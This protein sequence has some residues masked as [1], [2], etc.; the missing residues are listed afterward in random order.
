M[1]KTSD[2]RHTFL[3]YFERE[4]HTIV[5]SSSLVP[6][7]DPSLL[8]TNA[9]M[10]QFKDV[11]LGLEEREYSRATTS[12]RCVRAGG[13][14]NDLDN[15]GYT[16]RHHTFFEMLGN[17]SFGEYFKQEAI[18]FAWDLLTR[19]FG[20]PP[21]KLWITVFEQDDEAA[22]I[23]LDQ[24]GVHPERFSRC[25]EKDNFWVMGDTGPCGPCSEIFFDHGPNVSGGPPGS[26]HA[27]GDRYVEIWN[28]VFMQYERSS[29]S[30]LKPI[31]K[32]S[33]DTGMGL[34]RVAAIL[35]GVQDNYDIDLFQNLLN[36]VRDQTTKGPMEE[37]SL[38]V[39]SDHIRSCA[40][41]VSDGVVPSNE[42]RGYVLRRII[43]RALRHGQKLGI[44]EPFF[45]RLVRPLA[46]EMGDAYPSLKDKQDSIAVTLK[47]EEERFAET[48]HQGMKI[49]DGEMDSLSGTV[50][51]GDVA[52][53]LYDTYG[54][55]IDLTAD[56][57]RERNLQVDHVGFDVQMDAQRERAKAASDFSS[58][59]TSKVIHVDALSSL[60]V[61]QQFTGYETTRGEATVAGLF[62]QGKAVDTLRTDITG[63]VVL[64]R[65]PFYAESGGQVG[66]RGHIVRDEVTFEVIDTREQA[67]L[68]LHIGQM[69]NGG[70]TKGDSVCAEVDRSRRQATTLNHSAT[71]LM[72]AALRIVLGNH[73]EQ[74]GSLVD[75]ARTRF[76]F[77]HPQP[78][79]IDERHEVERMVN[80]EIRNNII[81]SA[82]IVPYREA[83]DGGAMA[84]FGE[85]YGDEVRVL[86][87]GDFSIELCGG[88]HVARTGDIGAFKI[89]S[90]SGIASSV[91]RI[92]AVT[93]AVA[94]ES[95]LQNEAVLNRIGELVRVD[96][97]EA[98]AKVGQLVRQIRT[99]DKEI[100]NLR[101][102]L[103]GQSARDITDD[104]QEIAGAMVV[105]QTIEDADIDTLRSACDRLKNRFERAVIVLGTVEDSKVRLVAGVT[106][107]LIPDV[108]AGELVNFVAEQ[109]GGKGGGRPDMAQ[110]G[111]SDP[112]RLTGA[113]RS[114]ADWVA[115][116]LS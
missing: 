10:V 53:R 28:L 49:L 20:L 13:K 114:V 100:Q 71:H 62:M 14:H 55:P 21:D 88:T 77:S 68:F 36:A 59:D 17:F 16:A 74:R 108:Q 104:L 115:E 35:Q 51:P 91:R 79:T 31:P 8:F 52:F 76:D 113:L 105:A 2:I 6:G 98:E 95:M 109:V 32:P 107:N 15:V 5:D 40:F 84:L 75:A 30:T 112:T 56:I 3:D 4:G 58:V 99:F 37:N 24:I 57:A 23:W 92:E 65:T 72:H 89:L 66:D 90:E 33:V 27:E 29:D 83:V 102:R 103:A 48:L 45:H 116:R 44:E 97:S 46:D 60:G 39:I 63:I 106:K 1:M 22:A 38:R 11:F 54:F 64:D 70:L 26:A 47:Q 67:G 110:A 42:G 94:V 111:G 86:R 41:L 12:Q 82:D 81:A 96:A 50:I 69:R 25:G 43:R 18:E 93:G 9:G 61:E 87:I 19:E 73:V 34:E 78:M 101:N 80:Q 85:K 7:N